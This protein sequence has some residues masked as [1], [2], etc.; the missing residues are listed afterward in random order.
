MSVRELAARLGLHRAGREWRGACPCCG[1]HDAFALAE[2]QGHPLAWCASCQ[3]REA[4]ARLL[5]GAGALPEWA[6]ADAAARPDPAATAQR[7]ARA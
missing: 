3:N 4:V 1:Y 6:R 5:R 2:R 7:R